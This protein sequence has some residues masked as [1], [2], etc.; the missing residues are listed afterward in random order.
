MI[1][2]VHPKDASHNR[3]KGHDEAANLDEEA[4][5]DDLVPHAVQV[6][7]DELVRVF[8]LVDEDFDLG[9]NSSQIRGI[10]P[11]QQLHLLLS[12]YLVFV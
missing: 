9:I 7:R 6:G 8:D 11:Q 3:T 12:L 10:R 4:H 2:Q 1:L 5:L